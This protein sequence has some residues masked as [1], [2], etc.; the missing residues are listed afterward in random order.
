[1]SYTTYKSPNVDVK[2]WI[3]GVPVESGAIDQLRNIASLP[4]AYHHVSAMPDVHVGIG[5]TVGSVIATKNAIIP[6][7]VG[8]DI[9]CGMVATRLS[10]KAEDLPD[11]L[12]SVR[13]DIEIMVPVG[14][15]QHSGSRIGHRFHSNTKKMLN[16]HMKAMNS[17][18]ESIL[19]RHPGILKMSKD[20]GRKAL[21]QIGTLGG[22]NHFIELCIDE[23][24]D[25]W[26]MLHS[27]SR[28]IGNCIGRYFIEKAKKEMDSLVSHLPDKDLAYFTDNSVSYVDYCDAV[29]WAQE[30]AA[31][32]RKAM[33]DL[34]LTSLRRHLPE[35][36]IT[37]EA[38]NCH[39]NYVTKELHF[40]EEV[41]VTRK[42]AV[43]AHKDTLGI[44]PGSMGARSYIVRGKGN[45]ESFC[46]CSHGAGRA[47]SRG[48][49]KKAFTVEDHEKATAGVECRKDAG[50]LDETPAAYKD[51]DA[52]MAAQSDLVET[53]HILKQV[54][55]VKG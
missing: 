13:K 34:V 5:A 16:G 3:T 14:F 19:E 41:H 37:E 17:N 55:C 29:D 32:N 54:L 49:A 31:R 51:I 40:G 1:M 28:G 52:V 7:A 38:I 44:I 22:G 39:H 18:F 45:E 4:I 2:A 20:V 23:N 12:Y 35:F 48:K 50:V 42:G 21:E 36:T 8:V 26:V 53:V 47:Y 30:Y 25:V 9:G 11:S 6:A 43:A 27:G 10:L 15:E 46:S 24:S 33:L